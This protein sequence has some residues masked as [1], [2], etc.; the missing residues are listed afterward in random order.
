MK[1][2][3]FTA[4]LTMVGELTTVE[5]DELRVR[6]EQWLVERRSR[7]SRMVTMDRL[8]RCDGCGYEADHGAAC[9]DVTECDYCTDGIMKNSVAR[10]RK[11]RQ[12]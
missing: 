8:W 2:A 6:I 9:P 1:R 10:G 5:L 7:D 11:K 4:I 3:E 12:P